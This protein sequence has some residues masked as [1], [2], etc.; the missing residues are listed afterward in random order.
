MHKS[1]LL[2]FEKICKKTK[3]LCSIVKTRC[4]NQ[5]VLVVIAL[6]FCCRE[7]YSNKV[8]YGQCRLRLMHWT[9]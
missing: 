5:K 9:P 3:N 7:K 2:D 1:F 6:Y 8:R 4:K